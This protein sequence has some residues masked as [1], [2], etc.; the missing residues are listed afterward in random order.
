M[1]SSPL[2]GADG[3]SPAR[4]SRRQV[5]LC[6]SHR[7]PMRQYTVHKEGP[8]TGRLFWNCCQ[9]EQ[10]KS[11]LWDSDISRKGARWARDNLVPVDDRGMIIADPS[12][13]A[14]AY[15][16]CLELVSPTE[17]EVKFMPRI[18]DPSVA[19][20]M[21]RF[22]RMVPLAAGMPTWV[23]PISLL[24][25][26]TDFLENDM[27]SKVKVTVEPMPKWVL[28]RYSPSGP[29]QD[30][31]SG[32]ERFDCN[33][34]PRDLWDQLLP[35]QKSG[36]AQVVEK[37]GGRAIIADDMGL[38][39]TVQAIALAA[40]Y[41]SDWPVLVVVP[42]SLRFHWRDALMDWLGSRVLE[43]DIYIVTCGVDFPSKNQLHTVRF[44]I[45]AYSL[46]DK[47][48]PRIEAS[49]WRPNVVIL[50]ESHFIKTPTTQRSKA[51]A[52]IVKQCRRALLLSGT[53]AMARPIE[54]FAQVD[55]VRPSLVGSY[56]P[57]SIRY[58][59]GKTGP[60]GWEARGALHLREL[61]TIL[62]DNVMIRRL[63]KDVLKDLPP[64]FRE[65]FTVSDLPPSLLKDFKAR[66]D[67]LPSSSAS[68]LEDLMGGGHDT[69]GLL[70]QLYHDTGLAKVPE[71]V[72]L[73]ATK[74]QADDTEKFLVF[75]HH[76]D[77]IDRLVCSLTAEVKKIDSGGVVLRV[78]GGVSQSV[79]PSL[80]RQF[81]EERKC[82]VMVL[83]I[84]AGSF[85]VTLTAASNV[86]FCELSWNPSD[87]LQAE[88]RAHRIGQERSCVNVSY[89]LAK[90]TLDDLMWP[91]I[92]RKLAVLSSTFD[93]GK[94][95]RID[96]EF[97]AEGRLD[98]D[99]GA[100]ERRPAKRKPV[101]QGPMDRFVARR[102]IVE[103]PAP[104][105][106]LVDLRDDDDVEV[107]D[108]TQ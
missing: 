91:M 41:T 40:Y 72:K 78:D 48:A 19:P 15:R 95:S 4:S 92:K 83:S 25:H 3:G 63:K 106:E 30:W 85:G 32:S 81:Q 5:P 56:K 77:V 87:L 62:V 103:D 1:F 36:V 101:D 99:G 44:L 42:S 34:L 47:T 27:P 11:F 50:D 43:E 46:M 108:L 17:F 24:E 35:F 79:R 88:D 61:N 26:L 66:M 13:P 100:P 9:P 31:S 59:D 102:R 8:N 70:A 80:I 53:P 51:T 75:A 14:A 6:T 28:N 98:H 52:P 16:A 68:D 73:V 104:V 10:C 55:C 84:Q 89:I 82:R 22:G 93:A 39:K 49:S 71:T 97:R 33:K 74:L 86:I 67:E 65:G 20:L 45:V 21:N 107:I 2:R 12:R 96:V 7:L 23:I 76:K 37:F 57:F 64:K 29:S 58:C 54:L 60:F 90:N 94:G 69:R 18:G 105:P 38:G